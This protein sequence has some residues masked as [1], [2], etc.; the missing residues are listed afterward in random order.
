MSNINSLSLSALIEALSIE[1][2][3]A[4]AESAEISFD[5]YKYLVHVTIK[6]SE[7]D[8]N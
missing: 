8:N 2:R 6:V 7:L 5:N 1:M 3:D 4:G